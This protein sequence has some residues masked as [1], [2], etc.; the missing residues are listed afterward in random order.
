M[1]DA[2]S[3]ETV[4]EVRDLTRR[5]G[6]LV[7]VDQVSLT[8]GRS[9]IFGLMGP[10]GAGKSTL[11]RMLTTLLPPTSGAA[12]V[13]GYDVVR[14]PAE[15]RRQLGYVPQ[16]L[17]ADGSLTGYENLLLSARLYGIPRKERA[18]RIARALARMDLA[19][20]ANHLVAHYSGGMIRRLEIAQSLLHRP[21]VLFLDEPTVGLDPAAREIVWHRL[22][23]LR[24]SFQTTMIVTTHRMDEIDEYCHRVALI[25]RG[26][27]VA[28][29]TPAELKAGIGPGAT[30][31][32]VF[33]RLVGAHDDHETEG[34][35]GAVRRERRAAQKHG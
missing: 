6:D 17:S 34:E 33:I 8:V 1:P 35:Y 23:D 14:Q 21:K 22:L 5:F 12:T 25:D 13:A 29:G 11:I 32:D 2:L 15:V 3:S 31:D 16:L 10:N 28:T 9:E 4:V 18:E 19:G 20:A 30:L 26:R 27:I 7:A 24:E